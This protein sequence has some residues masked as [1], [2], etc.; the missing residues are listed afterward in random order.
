MIKDFGILFL[1]QFS[2]VGEPFPLPVSH[3]PKRNARDPEGFPEFYLRTDVASA[4]L[5]EKAKNI[6]K[7]KKLLSP[8]SA[9]VR[10]PLLLPLPPSVAHPPPATSVAH[11]LSHSGARVPATGEEERV[12]LSL[13]HF[14]LSHSGAKNIRHRRRLSQKTPA[15]A[16]TEDFFTSNAFETEN[17]SSLF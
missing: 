9:H 1:M 7:K 3:Y 14:C 16:L 17:P 6:K 8:L 11:P 2:S 15:K 12:L 5:Q 13:P 4:T 10:T